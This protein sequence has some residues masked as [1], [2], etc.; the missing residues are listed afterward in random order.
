VNYPERYVQ[1]SLQNSAVVYR[2][3][4]KYVKLFNEAEK[5]KNELKDEDLVV[6]F[7]NSSQNKIV[8]ALGLSTDKKGQLVDDKNRVL[9]NQDFEPIKS[10]EFGGVLRGSKVAIKR[11]NAELVK[12]FVQKK[13]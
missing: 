1:T 4:S 8:S 7:D 13:D 3:G 5:M 9:T 11:D 2:L 6:A 10:A 12:Y